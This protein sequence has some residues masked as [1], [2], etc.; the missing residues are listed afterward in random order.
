MVY[1]DI[2]CCCSGCTV[3]RYSADGGI[4]VGNHVYIGAASLINLGVNICDNV[5]VQGGTCVN[6]D[7]TEPGVYASQTFYKKGEVRIYKE[8]L[9]DR[10]CMNLES[11]AGCM[12]ERD[13]W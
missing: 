9:E 8:L 2:C 6:K 4:T 11:E 5:V 3:Y 12:W 7:I 13:R 1:A 10:D